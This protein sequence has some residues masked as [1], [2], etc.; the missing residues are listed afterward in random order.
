MSNTNNTTPLLFGTAAPVAKPISEKVQEILD[1][2]KAKVEAEQA[3]FIAD[4]NS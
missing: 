4:K 2:S 1:R 3:K